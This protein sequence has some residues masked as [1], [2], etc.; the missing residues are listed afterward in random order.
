MSNA[1]AHLAENAVYYPIYEKNSYFIC[2]NDISGI[3]RY[4]SN[5][6]VYF[7]QTSRS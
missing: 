7:S 6:L 4:N 2:Q 1:T 3:I 5:V